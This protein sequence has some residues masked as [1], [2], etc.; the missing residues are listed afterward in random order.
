[1]SVGDRVYKFG[2]M[3]PNT[4]EHGKKVK[5]MAMVFKNSHRKV[6]TR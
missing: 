3:E 2:P 6:Y 5:Q 1:M 4:K